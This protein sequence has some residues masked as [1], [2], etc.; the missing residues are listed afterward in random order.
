MDNP[1]IATLLDENS[2]PHPVV[3]EP[4]QEY[5]DVQNGIRISVEKREDATGRIP[6]TITRSEPAALPWKVTSIALGGKAGSPAGSKCGE[7]IAT[8]STQAGHSMV[9]VLGTTIDG[10]LGP[11]AGWRKTCAP[12]A[13]GGGNYK[14]VFQDVDKTKPQFIRFS[15]GFDLDVRKIPAWS[16]P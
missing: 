14:C 2:M 12:V 10:D 6:V 4:G 5:F 7:V 11:V 8:L 1:Y 3:I 15:E 9:G 13:I 16:C